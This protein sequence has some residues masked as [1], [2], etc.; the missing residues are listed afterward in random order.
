MEAN[1][2]TERSESVTKPDT[3][4]SLIAKM[5]HRHTSQVEGFHNNC[6]KCRLEAALDALVEK[7]ETCVKIH[8]SELSWY[9]LQTILAEL[10]GRG[11]DAE[12]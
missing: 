3:L 10:R 7:L 2:G 5:E 6:D 1:N 8:G 11:P 4:A 9:K 12:R